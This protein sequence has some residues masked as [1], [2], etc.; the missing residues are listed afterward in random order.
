LDAIAAAE[1]AVLVTLAEAKGSTPREAGAKMLVLGTRIADSIGGGQLEMLAIDAA[2]RMMVNGAGKRELMRYSLG[3]DLG[4]CCGGAVRMLLEPISSA[5]KTWLAEWERRASLD[6]ASVL[7]TGS[8][9]AK[10][11]TD[12]GDAAIR[13]EGQGDGWQVFEPVRREARPIWLYGAGHVGRALALVLSE[14]PFDVTWLDSR[15]DGFPEE[16]PAGLRYRVVP[17]LAAEVDRASADASHLVMTHSHAL[18]LEICDRILQR[19]DFAFLGL[20]GSVTKKARFISQLKALGHGAAALD[21]LIC[22]IGLAQ[23]P[24]KQP[25]AIAV[26]VAGQ[27]LALA[28]TLAL[29]ES[30][31]KQSTGKQRGAG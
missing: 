11:W 22:P 26:S 10:R 27:M 31:G 30:Q 25:M 24:G 8:D 13:I 23:V 3:P 29:A 9:G 17:Q 16:I 5:D 18:D 19:G 20:I 12:A 2:R 21:R 6:A 4:Q 14:L 1:P 28:Q 15:F 7:V